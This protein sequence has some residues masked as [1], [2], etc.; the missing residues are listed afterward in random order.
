MRMW[1]AVP[2]L[3]VGGVAQAMVAGQ[4][5]DQ[6]GTALEF[7]GAVRPIRQ[8]EKEHVAARHILVV[9]ELQIG[10]LAQIRMRRRD[11]L[12]RERLAAGDDLPDLRMAEQQTQQLTAGVAAGADDARPHLGATDST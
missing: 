3:V 5:D 11:R 4:V 12:A 1:L 10:A 8:A 2:P 6:G 7:V 9:D